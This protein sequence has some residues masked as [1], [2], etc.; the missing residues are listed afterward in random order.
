M[1]T[2]LCAAAAVVA[3]LTG[4]AAPVYTTPAISDLD[5]NDLKVIV[6]SNDPE[7][8]VESMMAEAALEARRGCSRFDREPEYVS[9]IRHQERLGAIRLLPGV[10]VDERRDEHV[11][12][13]LF[14]CVDPSVA[15]PRP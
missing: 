13:Y 5:D 9:H 15:S 6:N 12:E 1:E 4:C 3:L 7:A 14:A 2:R 11:V 10:S 8:T